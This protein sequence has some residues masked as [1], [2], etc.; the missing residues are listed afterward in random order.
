VFAAFDDNFFVAHFAGAA[1]GVD[2][3]LDFVEVGDHIRVAF[4]VTA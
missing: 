3:L 4:A 2:D 1:L